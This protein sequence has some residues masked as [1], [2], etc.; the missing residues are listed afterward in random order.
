MFTWNRESVLCAIDAGIAEV[1][2]ATNNSY[3]FFVRKHVRLAEAFDLALNSTIVWLNRAETERLL[4]A[5]VDAAIAEIV[6]TR[7]LDD[8]SPW[9]IDPA[10][11]RLAAVPMTAWDAGRMA[12]LPDGGY[13]FR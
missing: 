7:D 8:V 6:T 1:I 12:R 4:L 10:P 11:L 2:A 3:L 13:S 9:E 5:G